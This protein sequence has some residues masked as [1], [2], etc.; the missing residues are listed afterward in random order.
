MGK[1]KKVLRR[2][3]DTRAANARHELWEIL[4]IALA[5]VAWRSEELLRDGAFRADRNRNL[6]RGILQLEHGVP[7]HDTFSRVFRILDP[8]AF[9]RRRSGNSW[10]HSPKQTRSDHAWGG[11]N[12]R[13]GTAW[14]LRTRQGGYSAPHGQRLCDRSTHGAGVAQGARPQ[15]EPRRLGAFG[16]PVPRRLRRH[17]RCAALQPAVR[18]RGV[19]TRCR[20]RSGAQAK[21]G[22]SVRCRGAP[23][24]RGGKRS[25]AHRIEPTTTTGTKYGIADRPSRTP[26]ASGPARASRALRLWRAS[27]RVDA[28][29][30]TAFKP[31]RTAPPALD[32]GS[33]G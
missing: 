32:H 16:Y 20:L 5:A 11:G 7:S 9:G 6:F 29:G 18:H 13:Q 28:P 30:R 19:G 22:N 4:F 2:L 12:R 21:S 8:D 15:R 33:S 27:P 25:V 26:Q 17:Q 14:R 1:F 23:A 24:A 3:S 10:R 31:A